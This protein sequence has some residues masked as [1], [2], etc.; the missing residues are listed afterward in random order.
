MFGT[1][2]GIRP[3][4]Y[5]LWEWWRKIPACLESL[6]VG[7]E[8]P[9]SGNPTIP[10]T[11]KAS[12]DPGPQGP[13][14]QGLEIPPGMR[15]PALPVPDS[16]FHVG[17]VPS[18]QLNLPWPS[19]RP[20]PLRL[21]LVP[22]ELGTSQNFLPGNCGELGQC[23]DGTESLGMG[24]V[25]KSLWDHGVQP[26]PALPRPPRIRV[27]K[28]HIHRDLKSLREWQ[29]QPC[30]GKFIPGPDSPFHVGIVPSIPPAPPLAQ[31]GAVPSPPVPRSL[32]IGDP[33]RLLPLFREFWSGKSSLLIPLFPG[34]SPF[35]SCLRHSLY[36]RSAS[37]GQK[38]LLPTQTF[39]PF[40]PG[41]IPALSS[42]HGIPGSH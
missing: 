32:G 5:G 35:P 12:T 25:G 42:P 38:F 16:P 22:W 20:F 30:P 28:G 21:S 36:S 8:T 26:P 15:N 41:F 4:N 19:W 23:Q 33:P 18:I 17:I 24:Q 11:A 40:F 39:I 3:A 1:R 13:H 6:K 37:G 14:P 10:S 27:P 9:R 34:M 31:L 2:G 7:K 29:L